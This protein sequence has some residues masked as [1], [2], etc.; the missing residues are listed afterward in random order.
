MSQID[1][2]VV[3]ATQACQQAYAPYSNF[4]VGVCLRSEDD[5]LFSGCM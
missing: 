4:S 2:M 1:K 3:K 5:Q